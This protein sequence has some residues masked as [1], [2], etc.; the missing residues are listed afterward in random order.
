MNRLA[1]VVLLSGLIASGTLHAAGPQVQ[2]NAPILNFSLP[3][4]NEQGFRTMLVRGREAEQGADED[5][6]RGKDEQ[7]TFHR[8]RSRTSV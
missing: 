3:S 7:R 6:A 8:R 1:H 2:A 4:F 5:G